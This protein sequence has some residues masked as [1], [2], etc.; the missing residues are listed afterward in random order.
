MPPIYELPPD[1]AEIRHVLLTED[2]LLIRL[3]LLAVVPLVGMIVWL[4]LWWLIVSLGRAP[5]AAPAPNIPWWLAVVVIFV[6]VLPVHEFIHGVTIALFGY[7]VRYGAKLSKGVLYATSDHALFRRGQYLAI[8]LAPFVVITLLA[9]LIMAIA[10]QWL[11]YY[12]AIAAVFNAGGA[13]GDLWSVGV[14]WRYPPPLLVRD[15][16]DGFRLYA[17]ANSTQNSEPPPGA[18]S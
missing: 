18:G 9:M 13:V 4:A 14:I 10:P 11:G 2:R 1:Y 15:E 6:L 5:D 8:A 17:P 12:T 3:N 7:K 16:A